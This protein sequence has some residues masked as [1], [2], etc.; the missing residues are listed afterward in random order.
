M[1]LKSVS[2]NPLWCLK[3]AIPDTLAKDTSLSFVPKMLNSA[4]VPNRTISTESLVAHGPSWHTFK[5]ISKWQ[6]HWIKH[7]VT[8]WKDS[9]FHSSYDCI[10]IQD[11][12]ILS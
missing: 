12:Q 3:S 1:T 2:F 11:D 5:C 8:I 7:M 4:Y 9:T 6:I 10:W